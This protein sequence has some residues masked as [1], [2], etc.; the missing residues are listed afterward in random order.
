MHRLALRRPALALSCALL[1]PL[2]A[3][4]DEPN[5]D[6]QLAT[7]VAAHDV[8]PL[9]KK[10]VRDPEL[11]ELGRLLFFDPLLSGNRDISCATC[12][13]TRLGTGDELSVS[14][15]T[16]GEGLG[17]DRVLGAGRH[18]V[19]RNAPEIYN[20]G[21][22]LWRTMFWD[23]RVSHTSDGSF[24]S[25]AGDDLPA[26]LSTVLEIQAMFPVTS[27]DEMRG[28]AGDVGV[29][30]EDNDLGMLG[31][32]ELPRMWE[33]LIERILSYDEYVDRFTTVFPE[34]APSDLGFQHAAKAIAAFEADA[35]TFTNSP[36][37]KYLRGDVAA[38]TPA[39]K[40]GAILFYGKADCASCHSGTLM[41]DQEAHSLCTPQIG[42]GKGAAAPWDLGRAGITEDPA[43]RFAFRTPPLRN[44]DHTGPYMH[45]G[46][47][48]TLEGAIRHHLDPIG[49]LESYDT[50]ALREDVRDTFQHGAALMAQ[51]LETL[52][53]ELRTPMRLSDAEVRDLVQ[54][55]HAL[56][57]PAS[58]R[59]G[60][61]TP[62]RVPSGLPVD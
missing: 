38:L 42:P 22:A 55:M 27:R 30:G 25:P 18:L 2:T 49:A 54:F 35:F 20:R 40:R 56:T 52:P 51:M 59:L 37:D 6:D 21:N 41:T 8:G 9:P 11:V 19:P 24:I 43:D 33:L 4:S 29:T 62:V 45:D 58:L 46:A 44:V 34:I 53:E 23:L 3:C 39:Q 12:H 36:W 61:I 60:E 17:P 48:L 32:D 5:L 26:G 1:I 47:Y 14:V 10:K 50:S 16:G 7:L 28:N 57:D 31:D 13:H 15:G